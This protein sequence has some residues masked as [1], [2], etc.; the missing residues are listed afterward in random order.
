M[1]EKINPPTTKLRVSAPPPPP[2]TKFIYSQSSHCARACINL[3]WWEF[4]LQL[5]VYGAQCCVYQKNSASFNIYSSTSGNNNNHNIQLIQFKFMQKLIW[6]IIKTSKSRS[7]D[8]ASE[9]ASANAHAQLSVHVR[10]VVLQTLF[11]VLC[12]RLCTTTSQKTTY[13]GVVCIYK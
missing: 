13:I 6:I 10:I 3:L 11:G 5:V 7:N 1:I 12:T 2:H 9:R 8:V 4:A